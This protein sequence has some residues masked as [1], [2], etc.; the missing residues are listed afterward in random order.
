[1]CPLNH[2]T[3]ASHF[4]SRAIIASIESNRFLLAACLLW[5]VWVCLAP[6][7][8]AQ[9]AIFNT[10]TVLNVGSPGGTPLISPAGVAV[11]GSGNVYI[12]D[13]E[14]TASWS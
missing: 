2:N 5:T 8:R 13:Y 1:M 10:T 9:T 6:A 3:A 12:A 7:A 4:D 14:T 11:D